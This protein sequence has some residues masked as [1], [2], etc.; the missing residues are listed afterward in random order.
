MT[1]TPSR[2]G[3]SDDD[4]RYVNA[5]YQPT[6]RLTEEAWLLAAKAMGVYGAWLAANPEE[7]A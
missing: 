7:P 2:D 5:T 6:S 1:D 3:W 4:R